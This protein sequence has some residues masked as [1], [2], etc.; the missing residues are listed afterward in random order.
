MENKNLNNE[1]NTCSNNNPLKNL[2]KSTKNYGIC[3][4]VIIRMIMSQIKWVKQRQ[5]YRQNPKQQSD[6]FAQYVTHKLIIYCPVVPIIL[7]PNTSLPF[8][9]GLLAMTFCTHDSESY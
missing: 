3:V 6:F 4:F 2:L 8:L 7:L 5:V 1:R 9:Q